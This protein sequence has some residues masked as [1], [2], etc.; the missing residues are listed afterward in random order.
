MRTL[1]SWLLLG[2]VLGAGAVGGFLVAFSSLVMPALRG[3]PGPEAVRAMQSINR[4]ATGPVV[5]GLLLGTAALAIAL[6]VRSWGGGGPTRVLVVAGAVLFLVGVVGVTGT[7]NVPLN[8]ALA[9]LDAS[10]PATTTYWED[11]FLGRWTA[12]NTV[13]ALAALGASAAFAAAL[14]R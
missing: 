11:T 12:W 5:L 14:P 13:R 9:G 8:E 10:A 6:V 7:V 4:T 1:D 3:V 2:A